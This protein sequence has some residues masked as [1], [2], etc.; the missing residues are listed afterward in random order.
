MT[1]NYTYQTTNPTSPEGPKVDVVIPGDLILKL[2]KDNSVKYQNFE[3][4]KYVLDNPERIFS[5][6]RQFNEGGWCYVGCPA[7]WYIKE[8]VC[9]PFPQ[10]KI[11]AVYLNINMFL[12]EFRA[13]F[14]ADDDSMCPKDWKNRY[15]GLVWK[16]TS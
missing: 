3:T 12:Y 2:H 8:R 6:V 7:E 14:R 9:V 10:D 4:A 16:N 1:R 11:F 13:E 5:G 15:R